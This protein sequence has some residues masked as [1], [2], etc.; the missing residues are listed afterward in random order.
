MVRE[1]WE[2]PLLS[3]PGEVCGGGAKVLLMH[4]RSAAPRR[5]SLMASADCTPTRCTLGADAGRSD[6]AK[7]PVQDIID[8]WRSESKRA[9]RW[10]SLALD[11]GRR[12][13]K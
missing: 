9:T 8:I 7:I 13:L 6:P 5:E 11:L 10:R 12:W 3:F 1:K 2:I 4:V